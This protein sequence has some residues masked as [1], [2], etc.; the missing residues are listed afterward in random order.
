M[1]RMTVCREEDNPSGGGRSCEEAAVDREA[2]PRAAVP[3]AAVHRAA[4]P[5]TAVQR[6][7]V[8]RA[9]ST[10]R[11]VTVAGASMVSI[12]LRWYQYCLNGIIS[13]LSRWHHIDAI[14]MALI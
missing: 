13:I 3:R 6:A 11:R 5:R 12:P 2:A 1:G 7:A 10:A 14:E 9:A 8:P 4:V